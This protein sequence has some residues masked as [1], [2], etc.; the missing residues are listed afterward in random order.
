MRILQLNTF[1]DPVGGAEIYMLSLAAELERR[2]HV[3][4]RFGVSTVGERDEPGWRALHRAALGRESLFRDP[5]LTS[6][7]GEVLAR[8]APEIV[9]VHNL[10]SLPLEL[11]ELLARSGLP[12]VQTVH[13]YSTVCPNTWC[14][15]PDGTACPGGA[16]RKCFAHGCERNYPFDATSVLAT[17]LRQR[18]VSAFSEV[19]ICPSRYLAETL[20]RHGFR[21]VRHLFYFVEAERLETEERPRDPHSLLYMGRLEPEKGLELLLE[22][23]PRVLAA[24]PETTLSIVGD[25]SVAGSLRERA[26]ALGLERAVHF[27]E[28]VPH[29]D[30]HRFYSTATAK[31]LP[32]IWTENSPLAA[33]ECLLSGLPLIGS[34][35]GGIPDLVEEGRTGFLFEPRNADDLADKILRLLD[36]DLDE[37][38]ALSTRSRELGARFTRE[39]NVAGV[40]A[41]YREVLARPRAPRAWPALPVDEDLLVP[42]DRMGADVRRLEGLFQEHAGYI[43]GLDQRYRALEAE[44]HRLRQA[45]LRAEHASLQG[46]YGR[47]LAEYR[48]QTAYVDELQEQVERFTGHVNAPER[49][50]RAGARPESFPGL[51]RDLRSRVL[52]A[53][54]SVAR[55][56]HL[57]KVLR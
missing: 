13:D 38:A 7:L 8:L 33:Y 25:G 51:P 43:A 48:R 9:H 44:Y 30:V 22:A 49:A 46:E 40:E 10:H 11:L 4:G 47:L 23:L 28:K 39:R 12:I 53:V 14:V 32:S 27:H 3:V 34:R 26:Q 35:I 36:L 24:V 50:R 54:R 41:I 57:P 56:L 45:P 16:G 2:G 19:S 37:R 6:A 5:G 42:L 15:L 55:R 52:R 1:V 31:V 18:L 29:E 21:D 20:R 17:M